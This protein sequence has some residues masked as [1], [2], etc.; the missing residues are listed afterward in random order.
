ML[1]LLKVS[2]TSEL[3]ARFP[4]LTDEEVA[5]FNCGD[6]TVVCT[7]EDFRVDFCR[8]WKNLSLNKLARRVILQSFMK[9]AEGGKFPQNPPPAEYLNEEVLGP[10]VDQYMKTLHR[11][12]KDAINPKKPEDVVKLRNQRAQNS[13]MNTVR[14]FSPW[15]GALTQTR[16]QLWQSRLYVV[17]NLGES[18]HS[19]LL[20]MM[21]ACNMSG[22][23]TDPD[24]PLPKVWRIIIAHWQSVELRNLLW[25]LDAKYIAW[26]QPSNKEQKRNGGNPTRIRVVRETSSTVSGV[27]PPG[28]WHNCY[29]SAWLESLPDWEVEQLD[30]VK[31]DYPFVLPATTLPSSS[32]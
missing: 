16:L 29:N 12:F 25:S 24:T 26:A 3:P 17:A 1:S 20:H 8:V 14:M 2:D 28:L 13:R 18:R 15:W 22:D 31:E 4:K 27:A 30:I 5:A 7:A 6:G 10:M 19:A 11:S 21:V 23:E 32:S 9:K